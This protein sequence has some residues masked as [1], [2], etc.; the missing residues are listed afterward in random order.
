MNVQQITIIILVSEFEGD[1]YKF[2]EE[3]QMDFNFF[4]WNKMIRT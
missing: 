1:L 2:E 4:G 3:K